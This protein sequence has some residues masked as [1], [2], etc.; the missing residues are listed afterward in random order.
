MADNELP[1]T[2]S[3]QPPTGGP[4]PSTS[5][6]ALQAR[7]DT[8]VAQ[9][10]PSTTPVDSVVVLPV[11]P[12]S[13]FDYL[14]N[15]LAGSPLPPPTAPPSVTT[16]P[17]TPEAPATPP[18]PAATTA[19]VAPVAPVAP[20]AAAPVEAA[21]AVAERSVDPTAPLAPAPAA[22]TATPTAQ[23]V[24]RQLPG[25][26]ARNSRILSLVGQNHEEQAAE[27]HAE[28]ATIAAESAPVEQT[29][30]HEEGYGSPPHGFAERAYQV[31]HHDIRV[32]IQGVDVSNWLEGSVV[33]TN[34]VGTEPNSCDITLN[35]A[36]D[37]FVLTPDN[38]SGIWRLS[39]PGEVA[40]YDETAKH[41]IYEIKNPIGN[42]PIDDSSG[43]RMWPL[44]YYCS[45]FHA[46]DPIRVWIRNPMDIELDEWIPM[47]CGYV[48]NVGDANDYVRHGSTITLGCKDIRHL[49]SKMRTNRNSVLWVQPGN[50]LTENNTRA[51]TIRGNEVPTA[52]GGGA[53]S[54]NFFEDLVVINRTMADPWST[55]NLW[56]IIKYLTYS[57]TS[58]EGIL[59]VTNEAEL[60]IVEEDL[61]R[62][63]ERLAA[64]P[65]NAQNTTRREQLTRFIATLESRATN[66]NNRAP[67]LTQSQPTPVNTA[68]VASV[69]A[70]Q[71]QSIA[72][73][74]QAAVRV[75]PNGMV[76]NPSHG[77]SRIG[78]I[79]K[80]KTYAYPSPLALAD[81][82]VETE[83]ATN[84]EVSSQN[85]CL[86]NFTN[87]VM[88]GF[89]NR[90]S[91]PDGLVENPVIDQS[92]I[93]KY[94]TEA[95]VQEAGKWTRSN[96]S[97]APDVQMVHVLKPKVSSA[98]AAVI[99]ENHYIDGGAVN[100]QYQWMSRLDLLAEACEMTDYRF[101]VS[102]SGDLIF[103]FPMYDFYP[104]DFSTL[105][106]G[107][108]QVYEFN[109]DLVS[110][111]YN[112]ESGEIVNCVIAVGGMT[113]YSQF[114]EAG[115]GDQS[116]T[117]LSPEDQPHAIVY[118]PT[119]TGRHGVNVKT[120]ALPRIQSVERLQQIATINMQKWFGQANNYSM[121]AAYRPWFGLNRVVFNAFR[122]RY[123]LAESITHTIP[124]R[125]SSGSPSTSFTLSYPRNL[126]QFGVPRFFTGGSSMPVYFGSIPARGSITSLVTA[127]QLH[128]SSFRDLLQR[129]QSEQAAGGI[130]DITHDELIRYQ[131]TNRA[132]FPQSADFYNVVQAISIEYQNLTLDAA[133]GSAAA[134]VR[135]AEDIQNRILDLQTDTGLSQN[136]R[137]FRMEQLERQL[138]QV[139]TQINAIQATTNTDATGGVPLYGRS[140]IRR[141]E[142]DSQPDN[143]AGDTSIALCDLDRYR[144]SS[145]LGKNRTEFPRQIVS[146]YSDSHPGVDYLAVPGESVYAVADGHVSA[147]RNNRTYGKVVVINHGTVYSAYAP[148]NASVSVGNPVR[149][150]QIIGTVGTS[151]ES[152][153]FGSVLLHFVLMSDAPEVPTEPADTSS[154]GFF[155]P[156]TVYPLKRPI[157]FYL[158]HPFLERRGS[159]IHGGVDL[160]CEA[161]HI[162][163]APVTG[164]IKHVYINHAQI[165]YGIAIKDAQ[166]GLHG[167]F[168]FST[169]VDQQALGLAG[170]MGLPNADGTCTS[171]AV[172]E[173][174]AGTPVGRSGGTGNAH[175]AVHLHYQVELSRS[176]P[177]N[178]AIVTRVDIGPRLAA[179]Y[180]KDA[181][182]WEINP[183]PCRFEANNVYD[184]NS[185]AHQNPPRLPADAIESPVVG[186]TVAQIYAALR[187]NDPAY[188][189]PETLA[190]GMKY[191]NTAVG[192]SDPYGVPFRPNQS[193]LANSNELS[194]AIV[195]DK[196]ATS[197]S[198]LRKKLETSIAQGLNRTNLSLD[199]HGNIH[200][201]IALWGADP[202]DAA[203]R[204]H[205]SDR[206][207]N[208]SKLIEYASQYKIILVSLTGIEYNAADMTVAR[209]HQID[210]LLSSSGA[211]VFWLT[212]KALSTRVRAVR[213]STTAP[214][215]TIQQL[216]A[217]G[218]PLAEADIHLASRARI[219]AAI[220]PDRVIDGSTLQPTDIVRINRRPGWDSH[221][222]YTSV[223][224]NNTAPQM[225]SDLVSKLHAIAARV[226]TTAIPVEANAWVDAQPPEDCP[227][228]RQR[229]L[230]STTTAPP[231][232][233]SPQML[234][235]TPDEQAEV[236]P[237]P[238][239]VPATAAQRREA[240]N[241]NR[242]LQQARQHQGTPTQIPT[243]VTTP[244]TPATGNR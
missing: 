207:M 127:L 206:E 95:Q 186:K 123:A 167:L 19:P 217:A 55:M 18:A 90:K 91:G 195:G 152:T 14:I 94:W 188:Q 138:E 218:V 76:A 109:S 131:T 129:V 15:E 158:G 50:E 96:R 108:Q 32:Y 215:R 61:N 21:Q 122:N 114:A 77:R 143:G 83:G 142:D 139:T 210:E 162:V 112:P 240:R 237:N 28:A 201:S 191:F 159:G 42:N 103:E 134:F 170:K 232:P 164:T 212:H 102:G 163:L 243:T 125:E 3:P 130:S 53:F 23:A 236:T 46:M 141:P 57:T 239:A 204:R 233:G 11:A 225:A 62:A 9:A 189:E 82:E 45:I 54:P 181:N 154:S 16:P 79:T 216:V 156:P 92:T 151:A 193:G 99:R 58:A 66:G 22:A 180:G 118:C 38:F 161:N 185:G 153:N 136:E 200:S 197:N 69:S 124:V 6:A 168:H 48:V 155:V 145:P 106:R 224:A 7:A 121:E 183:A 165:G 65:A 115:S 60:H 104:A 140:G 116:S 29:N 187:V 37:R 25:L 31:F 144:W 209:V 5:V 169:A 205:V 149:R 234:I 184:K 72:P 56:Q 105:N 133:G 75:G 74:P 203:T 171:T 88:F 228:E 241:R 221:G 137:A 47:F 111:S 51:S 148:V 126:D 30:V 24:N 202:N 2:G 179:L 12:P 231:I 219:L 10:V 172:V 52:V 43:G 227:P 176:G 194:F 67:P 117:A 64:L 178:D 73:N 198:L 86:A 85:V 98:G 177:G 182:H 93:P 222:N 87:I 223:G 20:A 41:S 119:L 128:S 70:N 196:Y 4:T 220:P 229:L 39:P 208:S 34:N 36:L 59:N 33:I 238:A 78:R 63:R 13:A 113:G 160:G 35:N 27:A 81:I 174:I 175:G 80:G 84:D 100:T 199:P 110:D 157:R 135:R 226:N 230:A 150:N 8:Y 242:R 49:M 44:E 89:P 120:L 71:N 97:W 166:G 132:P 1:L 107:W 244:A 173:V 101:Y 190:T 146:E 26:T 147:V 17:A 40:D 213:G 68:N 211:Y 192:P 235:V 214:N